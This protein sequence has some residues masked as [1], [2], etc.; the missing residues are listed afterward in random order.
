MHI[1]RSAG[2]HLLTL[3]GAIDGK[4]E[5]Y[6]G[7]VDLVTRADIEAEHLIKER[8]QRSFPHVEIMGEETSP[9]LALEGEL[10]LVDPLDGTTNFLHGYPAYS[11]SIALAREGRVE[12]GAVFAPALGEMFAAR[13]GEGAFLNQDPIAVSRVGELAGS[14]LATGFA[15]QRRPGGTRNIPYFSHLLDR[16]HGIRRAGSA[17]LDLCYTAAGRIDGYWE[18]NLGPWDVAAG[19]LLVEEAGGTVTDFEGGSSFLSG[20]SI[21]AA[22]SRL[23]PA[24]REALHSVQR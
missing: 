9:D 20:R 15:C 1:A 13:R 21:V 3:A 18:F 22:N 24:L 23:H 4:V 14:L 17:A 5:R 12:A 19:S 10:W 6:K 16:T 11:V 8:L 2:D 7:P